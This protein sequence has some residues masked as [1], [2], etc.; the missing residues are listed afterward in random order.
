MRF[1]K[2]SKRF[3]HADPVKKYRMHKV[4][5]QWVV[6]G[7]VIG[8]LL[9]GA[10]L[11]TGL[12]ETIP[13]QAEQQTVAPNKGD[14]EAQA[15]D[16]TQM[17]E[18]SA[19]ATINT[20][21][22]S[23][24]NTDPAKAAAAGISITEA[25]TD[26]TGKQLSAPVTTINS[27]PYPPKIEGYAIVPGQSAWIIDNTDPIY[28]TSFAWM[29]HPE[30]EESPLNQIIDGFREQ[31]DPTA[32]G[33][34]TFNFVYQQD[35][36]QFEG[37]TVTIDEGGT[38]DIPSLVKTL[39]TVDGSDGDLSKVTVD[40]LAAIDT[41][42]PGTYTA[43]LSYYDDE[44][45]TVLHTTATV[46]VGQSLIDMTAKNV[47]LS[48]GDTFDKASVIES[49][50]NSD[51]T[52]GDINNV[53]IEGTIDTSVAGDYPIKV[54]YTD[55]NTNQQISS[56]VVVTVK[57]QK[58]W[59]L[60]TKFVDKETGDEISPEVTKEVSLGD[61]DTT[62]DFAMPAEI[63]GKYLSL[64]DSLLDQTGIAGANGS[65]QDIMSNNGLTTLAETIGFIN[66]IEL[67]DA[68]WMQGLSHLLTCIQL[69]K[70]NYLV[71]I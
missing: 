20:A 60:V 34:A 19:T 17:T 22:A 3:Y 57:E 31:L 23:K 68:L 7:N 49:I 40:N 18:N 5:K 33:T 43:K 61:S 24:E 38:L 1:D 21:S 28:L 63:D 56:D 11:S 52:P 45:A 47:T 62:Y 30:L 6:L 27:I 2:E 64:S 35:L 9:I 13:V 8:T 51:G 10:S 46:F 53:Q 26:T 42:V 4:K 15:D 25:F 66:N 48:V 58:K 50:T 70:E 54:T 67:T 14:T 32:T 71:M 16:K 69:T 55:P 37:N 65:L 39:K 29:V 12:L 59:T 44:F 41:S 36:S